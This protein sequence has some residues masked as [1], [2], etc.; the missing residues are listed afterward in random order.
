MTWRGMPNLA[1][2]ASF[3]S[4]LIGGTRPALTALSPKKPCTPSMNNHTRHVPNFRFVFLLF[5][6]FEG[7]RG[8]LRHGLE[9]E[10]LV[11]LRA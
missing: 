8:G 10:V 11:A 9:V 6:G 5:L 1:L 7:P 4:F 2:S 3:F